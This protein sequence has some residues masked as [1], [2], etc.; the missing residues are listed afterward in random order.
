MDQTTPT[1]RSQ[2]GFLLT[3]LVVPVWILSGAVFKLIERTPGNLP[4]EIWK[5]ANKAGIDLFLLLGAL[6]FIE[7]AM[8][9][10]MVFSARWARTA[11]IFM[12]SVFCLVL[13]NEMRVGNFTSCGCL[14]KI[15]VKPW[16]MLTVDGLLLLGVIVCGPA[17]YSALAAPRWVP[18]AAM[19]SII[20]AFTATFGLI[21]PER[22]VKGEPPVINNSDTP[23]VPENGTVAVDPTVNP[24]PAPFPS[25]FAPDDLQQWVGKPWR[26]APIFKLMRTWPKNMDSGTRYVVFYSR[27]C[28]HC[29]QMF[30][31]DLIGPI[32]ASVTVVEIPASRTQLTGDG[33]WPMPATQCEQLALSVGPLWMITPPLAIAVK[34]GIIICAE[35]QGHKNCLELP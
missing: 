4:G 21:L 8:I 30:E 32:G 17:R 6:I 22:T 1:L 10:F 18:I 7:F 2:I 15:P 23:V 5:S 24:D 28:E 14:G 12:L 35:E 9:I 13:L 31:E 33:A 34:D 3:R 16:Q 11:A 26:E 27:T 19:I 25:F 29:Q 20:A